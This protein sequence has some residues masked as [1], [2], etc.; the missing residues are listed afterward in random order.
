MT[1]KF[2]EC[3]IIYY[4][5]Y[6]FLPFSTII[7]HIC[8]NIENISPIYFYN[9]PILPDCE[10]NIAGLAQSAQQSGGWAAAPLSRTPMRRTY[11]ATGIIVLVEATVFPGGYQKGGLDRE[12]GKNKLI[13]HAVIWND[14]E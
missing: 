7:Q 5:F 8:P 9:K 2:P 11:Q 6:I 1:K 4:N 12:S 13:I 10:V 14:N 3:I